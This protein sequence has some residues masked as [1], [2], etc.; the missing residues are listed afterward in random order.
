MG[1]EYVPVTPGI[2]SVT[3]VGKVKARAAEIWTV[4]KIFLFAG[5]A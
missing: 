4:S 2:T 5:N 3:V 1:I